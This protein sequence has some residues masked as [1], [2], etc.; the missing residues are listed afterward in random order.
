MTPEISRR[1]HAAKARKRRDLPAPD[2][3]R[4]LPLDVPLKR[5]TVEDFRL[6]TKHELRLYP[7]PARRDQF[8]VT[9]D[10]REWKQAIGYSRLLAG[11]RK[12]RA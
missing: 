2:Y 1:M 6:G 11:V 5:I 10:G 9:V 12:A 4:P 8:R 3:P 7:S